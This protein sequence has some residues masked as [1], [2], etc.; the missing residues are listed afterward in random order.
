MS[1]HSTV[2]RL[3]NVDFECEQGTA[4]PPRHNFIHNMRSYMPGPHRRFLEHTIAIANIREYVESQ[5]S[6]RALTIAYDA[7]LAM[8]RSL[9]SK[10]MNLV[11]RYIIIKAGERRQSH[12]SVPNGAAKT[13][14]LASAS[15]VGLSRTLLT[16]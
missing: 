4:P 7:C 3:W 14:N 11:T 5:T 12:S 9:R 1:H 8:L 10:H 13:Q 15:Q 2:T 6:N 16:P